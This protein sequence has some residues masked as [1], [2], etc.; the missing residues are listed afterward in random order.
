MTTPLRR[1]SRT[2][3]QYPIG[4]IHLAVHAFADDDPD[5]AALIMLSDPRHGEDGFLQAS[6]M[7]P[8]L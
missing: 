2:P 7:I 8:L 6:E 3:L 1:R 4:F 5:R